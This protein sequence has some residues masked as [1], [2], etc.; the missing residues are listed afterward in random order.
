MTLLHYIGIYA[1]LSYVLG[2]VWFLFLERKDGFLKWRVIASALSPIAVPLLMLT[3]VILK[4][5][6][7]IFK[8][9]M[10]KKQ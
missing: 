10:R 1:A 8:W 7:A 2:A 4:I 6:E 9:Q 5:A 3:A